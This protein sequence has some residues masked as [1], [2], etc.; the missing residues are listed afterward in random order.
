MRKCTTVIS[1]IQNIRIIYT[2]LLA[3]TKYPFNL[4][5]MKFWLLELGIKIIHILI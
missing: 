1:S 3:N 2:E 4:M 5:M